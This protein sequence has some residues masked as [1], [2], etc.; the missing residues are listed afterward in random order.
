M[1]ASLESAPEIANLLRELTAADRHA[2]E[3]L[4]DL[5]DAQVNWRPNDRAWS[6]AQCLDHLA[7]TNQLYLAAVEPAVERALLHGRPRREPITPNAFER[8]FIANLEP[9]PKRRMPAPGKIV[10]AAHLGRTEVLAKFLASQERIRALLGRAAGLD[11][12]RTRFSNPFFRFWRMRAGSAFLALAAHDRR[13]L[14]QAEKVRG[15]E[16]FPAA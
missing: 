7:V 2:Q 16:R 1:N 12:N 11:L 3:L 5:T 6:L 10:P 15:N 9:P 14:L 4:A 8:W 13:H